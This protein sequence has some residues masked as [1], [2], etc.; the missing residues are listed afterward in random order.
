MPWWTNDC[1][2]N[3]LGIIGVGFLVFAYIWYEKTIK[4]SPRDDEKIPMVAFREMER[5]NKK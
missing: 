1:I 2:V 3:I 4:P 5:K